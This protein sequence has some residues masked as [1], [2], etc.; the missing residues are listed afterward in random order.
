M[1]H[2]KPDADNKVKR[3]NNRQ[4]RSTSRAHHCRRL[5]AVACVA[6]G[7]ICSVPVVLTSP[8]LQWH[9]NHN[10]RRPPVI[11]PAPASKTSEMIAFTCGKYR[12]V[13]RKSLYTVYADGSHLRRVRHHPFRSYGHISWSL[14]GIW[15][16]VV[17]ENRDYNLWRGSKYEIYRVRFDGLDSLRLTYNDSRE[18]FPVWSDDGSS[19]SFV[20]EKSIHQISVNG[21]E[22]GRSD[23]PHISGFFWSRPFD[24]SSDRQH[25]AFSYNHF[26]SYGRN[27]DESDLQSERMKSWVDGLEWA[28]NNEQILYYESDEGLFVYNVKTKAEDFAVNMG[29]TSDARWSPNGKWIAI[30]GQGED[31]ESGIYLYLVDIHTGDIQTVTKNGMKIRRHGGL[32]SWSPDSEWIAFANFDYSFGDENKYIGRLFKIR[33]DGTDLQQLRE[34]DCRITELSWS[35]K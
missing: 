9:I 29:V 32:I 35:P 6:L 28:P 20:S 26:L 22:I 25:Y 1:K 8:E 16:A 5:F 14:D 31:V 17:V 30:L 13:R 10:I 27:H 4:G 12:D 33:R 15:I 3:E 11:T 23:N 21:Q 2:S 19:I 24:W 34:L 7:L 18:S